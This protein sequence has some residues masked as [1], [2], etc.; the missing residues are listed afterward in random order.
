MCGKRRSSSISN[1]ECDTRPGAALSSVPAARSGPLP[2]PPRARN[3][4]GDPGWT[5]RRVRG[6]RGCPAASRPASLRRASAERARLLP[7]HF[8]IRRR[9]LLGL[10][11]PRAGKVPSRWR[12]SG[13]AASLRAAAPAASGRPGRDPSPCPPRRPLAAGS[14]VP[15]QLPLLA[16]RTRGN[17]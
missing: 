6:A 10:R 12:G 8:P 14:G 17:V 7:S 11:E 5:H 16:L 1:G 9:L 3:W 2:D 4:R 15:Q 13:R